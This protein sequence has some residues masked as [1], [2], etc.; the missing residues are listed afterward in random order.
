MAVSATVLLLGQLAMPTWAPQTRES[1]ADNEA[2]QLAKSQLAD[3]TKWLSE[4]QALG[5]V[6]EIGW[7]TGA[8]HSQ[9]SPTAAAWFEDVSSQDLWVTGWAAGSHW[10]EYP[11]V[12][13][14]SRKGRSLDYA[15]PAATTWQKAFNQPHQGWYGVNLAG[16]EFG[17]N[18]TAENPGQAGRDYFYEP[19]AS[20][21]YLASRGVKLVRL[22]LKWER[23]Q[24]KL[25]G[26][27]DTTAV[28]AVRQQLD[29]AAA[30]GL[31]VVLDLH[32]YGRYITNDNQNVLG[33]SQLSSQD[34]AGFWTKLA[35]E[36]GNHGAVVGI[37]IMNEPH[38]LPA[39]PGLTAVQVWERTSQDVVTALRQSGYHKTIAVAG[40]D[41]SS[42]ARWRQNHPQAWI[43]DPDANI[44][45]EAHHYWDA[46]GSGRYQR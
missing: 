45:Y 25:N 30:A 35:G 40:Y 46:D 26:P 8:G 20:Y 24:P 6:G 33:S 3:F 41:W 10:G 17:S 42:L 1:A 18:V 16:M 28:A 38:D 15:S 11:L 39:A 37:G 44:R 43:Q 13:Y 22:P 36:L 19:A 29:F 32:N 23:L 12:I 27:L 31:R 34:L 14:G 7:P 21:Q 9:W 5:F 2:T 4:G